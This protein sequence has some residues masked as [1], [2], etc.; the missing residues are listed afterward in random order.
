VSSSYRSYSLLQEFSIS[1]FELLCLVVPVAL[2]VP[3]AEIAVLAQNEK[4]GIIIN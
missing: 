4:I 3:H 2:L 1:S